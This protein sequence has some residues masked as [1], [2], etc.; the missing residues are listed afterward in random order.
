MGPESFFTRWLNAV[1]PVP[2]AETPDARAIAQQGRQRRL[3]SFT[4]LLILL[5]AAGYYTY[6]YTASA[7]VRSRAAYDEAMQNMRPG[8]YDRAIDL[9]TKSIDI[10]PTLPE[11]YVN[12]GIALHAMSQR[13]AALDDLG[14]ALEMDPQLTRAYEERGRIYVEIHDQE[15]AL[16]EI[17]RAH[18]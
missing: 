2:A 12:R 15:R 6:D 13:N 18:V 4:L 1:R 11:A 9:F 3:I 7:P 17:G 5:G 8:A 10:S 16:K 14:R